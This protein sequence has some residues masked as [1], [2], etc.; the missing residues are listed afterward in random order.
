MIQINVSRKSC[1]FFITIFSL[2]SSLNST[3]PVAV[4]H[5]NGDACDFPG[6]TDFVD[7]LKEKLNT[8]VVCFEQG[9]GFL[10]SWFTKFQ[11]QAEMACESVKNHPAFQGDFSVLGIS[12]GT[13]LA[14]YVIQKCDIKGKVKNFVSINGPHMGIAGIPHLTCGWLC[15]EINNLAGKVVYTSSF[16]DHLAPAGYYKDKYHLDVYKHHSTFLADLNNEKNTRSEEYKSRFSN[17]DKVVLIMN[18]KDTVVTP[19]SS[20]WFEFLD[21][22]TNK[23]VPLR[24]SKFYKEDYIGL[25]EL[26]TS[27]KIKFVKLL[28]DH[29]HFSDYDIDTYMIPVLG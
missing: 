10:T 15:D 25:R 29:I 22:E 21:P 2:F 5:G 16:Q 26:D 7:Y 9:N 4:F 14:R 18:E 13:L 28:G 1:I 3:L 6:T 27:G 23:V 20:A 24:D 8:T 19:P 11:R 12:Q 17:L